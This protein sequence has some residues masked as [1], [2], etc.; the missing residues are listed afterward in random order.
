MQ[1]HAAG[2]S[3]RKI[4]REEHRDR[5]T[6]AKVVKSDEM[7]AYVQ[8]LRE[9][10]Y[11]LADLAIAAVRR[12]LQEGDAKLAYQVLIDI[13]VVPNQAERAEML[14]Q[15][16]LSTEDARHK[17]LLGKLVDVALQRHHAYGTPIEE[18]DPHL[19][20][21]G[22]KV[23]EDTGKLEPIGPEVKRRKLIN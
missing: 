15:E 11:G 6:I 5:E 7:H 22:A 20:T 16:P 13:G 10:F 2:E 3:V 1:R 19:K 4:S 23:N 17:E 21:I 18:L 12:G 9:Q 8:G 14:A